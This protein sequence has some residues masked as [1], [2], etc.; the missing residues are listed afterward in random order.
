MKIDILGA[1]YSLTTED[2]VSSGGSMCY[3]VSLFSTHEIKVSNHNISE[4]RQADTLLHEVCHSILSE[5]GHSDH[6][7]EHVTALGSGLVSFLRNN[8]ALLP[9]IL[10]KEALEDVVK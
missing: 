3:G 9:V 4:K 8:S 7:E 2:K 5:A 10:G 6:S 1:E